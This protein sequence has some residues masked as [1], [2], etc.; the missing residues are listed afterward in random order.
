MDIYYVVAMSHLPTN[1]LPPNR[2]FV[3][4]FLII[5][6]K[7]IP[8]VRNDLIEEIVFF[9][10]ASAHTYVS[11]LVEVTKFEINKNRLNIFSFI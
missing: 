2:N 1:Y 6:T 7:L 5:I 9:I 8:E 3:F 10:H 4:V 11:N